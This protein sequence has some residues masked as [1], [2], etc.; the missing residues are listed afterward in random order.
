MTSKWNEE[1]E[2]RKR[3]RNTKKMKKEQV[4][5]NSDIPIK[6]QTTTIAREKR[7]DAR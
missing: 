2:N 1:N 6:M 3:R 5:E 4:E 7:R